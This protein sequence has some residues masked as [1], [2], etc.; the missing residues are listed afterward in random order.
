MKVPRKKKD[1]P[2]GLRGDEWIATYSDTITLL[3][4]FFILLYSFSSVNEQKLKEIS[5]ALQIVLSGQSADSILE[6]N[7]ED[8]TEPIIGDIDTPNPDNMDGEKLDMY[9]TISAFIDKKKLEAT[10]EVKEDDRG[11]IIQLKYNI[12]F[13]SGRADLREESKSILDK[14]SGLLLTFPNKIIIEGHTD[15][16]P[17]H[18]EIFDSNWELSAIRAVNVVRY[19]VDEKKQDALRFSAAGYGEQKPIAENTSV[20]GRDKNRRVNILIIASVKDGE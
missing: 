9:N 12:L 7:L 15:N 4:T 16:V 5:T 17:M 20:E 18:N 8:G 13:Q 11:I 6:H 14:I 19:F 10:V 1:K 3:L 2:E